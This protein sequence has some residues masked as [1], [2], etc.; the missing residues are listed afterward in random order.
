MPPLIEKL[1]AMDIRDILDSSLT[2]DEKI[3]A[4]SEKHLN[5]PP[6][7]GPSGLINAYYP[8]L[9][10]VADKRLYPD[11]VAEHGVQPVTR[12]TL[13]FQR[14]AVRRI[15]ELV[16]GIPVK[17]VYK[18]TN[19]KETEV[20]AFIESVYERNRIDSL[21]IERCNLLF[22]CCEVLT[23]W[24]AIEE[25]NNVYGVHSPYKLRARNFAPSS[26]DELYPLFDEYGDM[27]AMSV[28]YTRRIQGNDVRYFDT[29][30]ADRHN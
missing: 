2:A 29:Y 28:A 16:C 1:T 9:H 25:P 19:D 20:A 24:Y 17:R 4:L 18:P 7:R 13:D 14:L 11:I 30:T 8:S 23:L 15:S 21:N 5:I 27:I 3:S 26:G 22:S 6:W 12:I 10:P